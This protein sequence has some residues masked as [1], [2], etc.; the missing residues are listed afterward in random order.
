M[1]TYSRWYAAGVILIGF[2]MSAGANQPQTSDQIRLV[3]VGET[4]LYIPESMIASFISGEEPK[5]DRTLPLT[6]IINARRVVQ[7][8][9]DNRDF[10]HPN[11][12]PNR[13]LPWQLGFTDVHLVDLS[14]GFSNLTQADFERDYVRDGQPLNT[15]FNCNRSYF[16]R[17]G[18]DYCEV[19]RPVLRSVRIKYRWAGRIV[20]PATWPEM[21]RRVQRIVEW[22][23]TPPERRP[24]MISG[25]KELR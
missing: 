1:K 25:S 4:M 21:D 22:L 12:D 15:H 7:L 18:F 10:R 11:G 20:D 6:T 16:G 9:F 19:Q 13:P 17:D 24:A 5:F 2:I 23:A 3:K 14:P 8:A